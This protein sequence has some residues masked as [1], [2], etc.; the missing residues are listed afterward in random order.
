MEE[1]I[2]SC[3]KPTYHHDEFRLR[4]Y[5]EGEQKGLDQWLSLHSD[6]TKVEQSTFKIDISKGQDQ[7]HK[8][9]FPIGFYDPVADY[10]ELM[11]RIDIKIFLSE[12]SWFYHRFKPLFCWLCIPL[13]FRSGSRTSS[14]NQFMT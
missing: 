12:E 3:D 7:Q 2:F 6:L 14:V 9:V 4:K 5:G 13:F 11:R 10:L 8:K 1:E